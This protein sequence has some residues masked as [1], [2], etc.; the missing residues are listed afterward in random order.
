MISLQKWS[1]ESY[2]MKER[3]PKK[4]DAV[5]CSSRR[6]YKEHG[7]ELS[8]SERLKRIYLVYLDKETV[9]SRISEE[10]EKLLKKAGVDLELC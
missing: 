4:E 6:I 3:M 1:P 2:F 5:I 8:E 7:I 9:V 10:P